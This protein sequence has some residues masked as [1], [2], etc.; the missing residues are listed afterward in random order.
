MPIRY[1][2]I[3]E[4]KL[5]Y[6]LM[7]NGIKDEDVFQHWKI[8]AKDPRYVAP[9]KKIIDCRKC[10]IY[11]PSS[12][13]IKDI[14]GGKVKLLEKFKGE[15]SV[16]IVNNDLDFGMSRMLGAHL[17]MHGM[18]LHVVRSLSAALQILDV[19]LSE[20]DLAFD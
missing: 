3:P 2:I 15:I 13:K 10:D 9:M 11:G 16:S 18:E 6:A 17:T 14:L 8:L 19:E 12:E 20:D 7:E 1:K 5:V 4:K